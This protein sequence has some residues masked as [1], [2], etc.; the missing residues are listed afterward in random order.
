MVFVCVSSEYSEKSN[1]HFMAD[2]WKPLQSSIL[3][4][5]VVFRS[6][7]GK[8]S[9]SANGHHLIGSGATHMLTSSLHDAHTT[10]GSVERS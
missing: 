10:S 6:A 7:R 2:S 9:A 4:L 5:G 3:S 8:D 1:L